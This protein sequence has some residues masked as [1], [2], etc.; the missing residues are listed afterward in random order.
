MK[1]R[2][3][4]FFMCMILVLS[5]SACAN[6]GADGEPKITADGNV[7]AQV[8]EGVL[9][10]DAP[11]GEYISDI[12]VNS[13]RIWL[14][15]GQYTLESCTEKTEIEITS[16]KREET[17]AQKAE[18]VILS[19]YDSDTNSYSVTWRTEKA[20]YPVVKINSKS[21]PDEK[22]VSAYC[23]ECDT[24]YVNR[25]VFY[26]LD[27]DM[28]Y[29]Y[30]IYNSGG[31][32]LYTDTFKTGSKTPETVTFMHVSDTQDEDYN[33]KVWAKLMDN[34]YSNTK[35]LDF[36]LHTGDMVQYGGKE[37]LWSQM[38]GNVQSY[39]S[40]VPI[41]LTS[42]NHSYWSDYLDGA[43]DIEYN[44]TTVNLPKQDTEN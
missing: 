34:A 40:S 19:I 22:T 36:I 32:K 3:L 9:K 16:V 28:E 2:I 10:A 27:Y 29:T 8:T 41:M 38:I 26:N 20:D 33:G 31:D 30:T 37:E 23:D 1:K 44:H 13:Q 4:A 11:D 35:N 15:D 42:G 43:S 6:S 5:A 24:G 18:S 39:V 17:A 21:S 7:Q 12:T 14:T 25:A